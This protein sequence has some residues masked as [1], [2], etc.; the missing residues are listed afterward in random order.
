MSILTQIIYVKPHSS[1]FNKLSLLIKLSI[2]KLLQPTRWD[3]GF[4]IFSLNN[5]KI[6]LYLSEAQHVLF[7][8]KFFLER[9]SYEKLP[10]D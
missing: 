5:M 8:R 2:Q 4:I 1:L 7:L 9:K 6:F 10:G 3:N